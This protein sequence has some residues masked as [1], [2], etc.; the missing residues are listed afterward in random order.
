MKE[1]LKDKEKLE[2]L[3]ELER[4][5]DIQSHM[6]KNNK[7]RYFYNGGNLLTDEDLDDL[8]FEYNFNK[9]LNTLMKNKQISYIQ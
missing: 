5:G 8:W 9:D 2:K 4:R 1:P 7:Y 3:Y 6:D